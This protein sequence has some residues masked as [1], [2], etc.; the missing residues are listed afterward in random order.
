MSVFVALHLK[1]KDGQAA[2]LKEAMKNVVP[3]MKSKDGCVGVK[4][5]VARDNS[6]ALIMAEFGDATKFDETIAGAK[7]SGKFDEFKGK[8]EQFAEVHV[9]PFMVASA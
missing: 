4:P 3:K 2:A 9:Q 5:M 6:A 8:L 1:I 7:G